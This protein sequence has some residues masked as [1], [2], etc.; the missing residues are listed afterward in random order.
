MIRRLIESYR[1]W[2]LR[3]DRP[4]WTASERKRARIARAYARRQARW[5]RK[6]AREA[7]ERDRRKMWTE[8]GRKR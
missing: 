4:L 1:F 7:F 8:H 5:R 3:Q 6:Q 2:I